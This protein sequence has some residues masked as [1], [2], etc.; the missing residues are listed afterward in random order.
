MNDIDRSTL[1]LKALSFDD[2]NDGGGTTSNTDGITPPQ[3]NDD[4]DDDDDEEDESNNEICCDSELNDNDVDDDELLIMET[5]IDSVLQ[6]SATF[7]SL[8][9]VCG[10]IGGTSSRVVLNWRNFITS[11]STELELFDEIDY[12]EDDK[13]VYEDLCYVTFSSN[14]MPEVHKKFYVLSFFYF[15]F[16]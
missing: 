10:G 7:D 12:C 8:S 11:S 15:F 14:Q 2:D 9:S 1:E 5:N 6:S 4:D 13:Q 3:S 16:F